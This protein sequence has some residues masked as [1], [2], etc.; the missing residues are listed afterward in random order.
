MM[1]LGQKDIT[2]MKGIV[3]L[4]LLVLSTGLTLSGCATPVTPSSDQTCPV[5]NKPKPKKDPATVSL[6][7]GVYEGDSH[8]TVIGKA[9][10]SKYNVAGIKRQKAIIKDRLRELAASIGGDAIIH[11]KNKGKNVTGTVVT[12]ERSNQQS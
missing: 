12:A 7:N 10:V 6:L 5:K 9:T 3:A 8:Y 11:V 4:F 2:A 1:S